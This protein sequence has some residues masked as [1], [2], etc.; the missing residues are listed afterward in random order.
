MLTY[1]MRN[2]LIIGA[3]SGIGKAL[4]ELLVG[5]GEKVFGTYSSTEVDQFGNGVQYFHHDVLNAED[6]YVGVESLDGL[7]YCP[8]S[9]NLKPFHR[10]KPQD[11]VNDFELQVIG[12]IKIVQKLLPK[13]KASE[14]ASIVF[15]STIAV[16]QGFNFHT[17]VATSKGAIE[18]LAKALAAELAPS[19][20][21]NVIA[22]SLT[23]TPLAS[24][25][26]SSEEKIEANSKRH[27]LKRVGEAKD[28]AEAAAFLL[29]EK[30]SWMTGQIIH[31][32]G[33]LSTLKI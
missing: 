7:V 4:A 8:G 21:V 16:Q 32:D 17:Q 31:I 30:S 27:P 9:I 12:G 10:I 25:L 2:N 28:I 18:G 15:F 33:G 3:S 26:L 6:I 1:Q 19:V 22:P 5:K 14:N 20:R 29:S 11:F 24:K 13:L 23:N